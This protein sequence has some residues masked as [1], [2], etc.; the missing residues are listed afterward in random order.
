MQ[1]SNSGYKK[2][3]SDYYANEVKTIVTSVTEYIASHAHTRFIMMYGFHDE[4][5]PQKL[6]E[7]FLQLVKDQRMEVVNV[8]FV[9]HDEAITTHDHWIGQTSLLGV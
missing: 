7:M 3:C 1:N 8:G 4:S 6:K 2:K 5:V 9:M